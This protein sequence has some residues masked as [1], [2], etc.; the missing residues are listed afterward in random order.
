MNGIHLVQGVYILGEY[1]LIGYKNIRW[2]IL[3]AQFLQSALVYLAKLLQLVS[4]FSVKHRSPV[5][6]GFIDL[7]TEMHQIINDK[8]FMLL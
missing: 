7:K 1:T 2:R 5:K 4:I 8:Q 6:T 3:Q